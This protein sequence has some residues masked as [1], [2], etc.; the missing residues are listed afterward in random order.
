[1][2]GAVA[3]PEAPAVGAPCIPHSFSRPSSFSAGPPR[4]GSRPA[5]ARPV[6]VRLRYRA[7]H[8]PAG[9]AAA[10]Y[11]RVPARRLFLAGDR[12]RTY[13][14][15]DGKRR[16]AA[17]DLR[18]LR[19]LDGVRPCAGHLAGGI[20]RALSLPSRALCAVRAPARLAA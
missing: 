3:L 4:L 12:R 1:A 13:G 5:P 7:R 10:L 11:R 14:C 2:A 17:F 16:G 8:D 20:A 6:V 18:R 19:L 15:I 9:E